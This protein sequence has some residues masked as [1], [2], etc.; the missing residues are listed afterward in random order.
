MNEQER[1]YVAMLE[2]ALMDLL[3]DQSW[4]DINVFTQLPVE[5]CY[6][7]DDLGY[8]LWKMYFMEP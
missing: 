8:N 1:K 2:K 3:H 4:T 7:L 5:R 6:E